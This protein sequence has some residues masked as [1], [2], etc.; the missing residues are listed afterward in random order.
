M[1]RILARTALVAPVAIA[2]LGAACSSAPPKPIETPIPS[3][4]PPAPVEPT[5]AAPPV[6]EPTPEEKARAEALAQLQRD[7]EKMLAD[8]Q[9]ELARWTPEL[10]AEAKA[11]ADKT[12]P[13]TRAALK[14]VLAGKHRRPANVER[15]KHRHPTE[16]LEFFGLKP[17]MTVLEYGPGEGW[18][19]ELLAPVLAKKGKLVVTNADPNGPKDERATFYGERFQLFLDRAPELY[20]KVQT[21]VFTPKAPK[22][23]LDGTVDLALMMRSMHGL[24]G[25]GQLEPVLA[26]IH[27]A[28]KPNGVL[29]VEQHRAPEG[30]NAE[31][32]AKKGYL[33]EKWVI[34]KVEAA[35][36]KLAARSEINANPKDTKDHPAGVWTLPPTLRLGD[37]DREKYLAI[38]ESDRMTLRFVKV[39][40]KK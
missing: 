37:E 35:G 30:A 34:E 33:P 10:R 28:L 7:R 11:L 4:P 17:T 32:S 5:P 21:I 6:A 36:F 29:G 23:G 19:T 13:N 16:T 22:L 12:Y 3:L 14:A 27:A 26:E 2:V 15:D 8:H 38:G 24:A 39:A 20:G 25:A 40:S 18:W 9:S 31:E 1:K